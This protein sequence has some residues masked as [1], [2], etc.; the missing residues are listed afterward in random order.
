[1]YNPFTKPLEELTHSDI[2]AFCKSGVAENIYLDYKQEIKA[3]KLSQSIASFANTKG[4]LLLIGVSEDKTTKLPDKWDG[5]VD[6][7]TLSETLNQIIANVTPIPTCRYVIVAHKSKGKA[8]VV[9]V[10]EEGASAPYFTVHKPVVYV[11]TGDI[12]TPIAPS[13]RASLIELSGRGKVADAKVQ[14]SLD[15]AN[16][17][18]DERFERARDAYEAEQERLN[19]PSQMERLMKTP[20]LVNTGYDAPLV[21][22]SIIPRNPYEL[23]DHK[24]LLDKQIEFRY[25]RGGTTIPA[26]ILE[27]VRYGLATSGY[28]NHK[29][30]F[31]VPQR[32][33]RYGYVSKY[34]LIQLRRELNDT[35]NGRQI[36]NLFNALYSVTYTLCLASTYYARFNYSGSLKLIVE[37]E[38]LDKEMAMFGSQNIMSD[39]RET[40]IDLSSYDWTVDF[41]THDLNTEG[42]KTMLS[43][44]FTSIYLDLGFQNLAPE[45]RKYI[46]DFQL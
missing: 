16:L 3:D 30:A 21:V 34:G 39:P 40:D 35:D 2:E 7:G 33:V 31:N 41:S 43:E 45:A 19:P 29:Q 12:S 11:R 13:D 22:S 5:I 15:L 36:H 6:S 37:L 9:I 44:L 23:T 17:I 14:S 24:T 27:P 38:N 1:M 20:R 4:G 46:D 25:S 42:I 28:D 32:K 8:F 10:T 26:S 18:F